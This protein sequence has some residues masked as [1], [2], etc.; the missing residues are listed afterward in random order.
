MVVVDHTVQY[1]KQQNMNVRFYFTGFQYAVDGTLINFTVATQ[2][3]YT[4]TDWSM[5]QTTRVRFKSY[6][7]ASYVG[8]LIKRGRIGIRGIALLLSRGT[9]GSISH[10]GGGRFESQHA[11]TVLA[12]HQ[13][14]ANGICRIPV[15][16]DSNGNSMCPHLVACY[17]GWLQP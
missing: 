3:L 9:C 7:P 13:N 15:C 11:C 4:S 5:H 1:L 8:P 2:P 17:S 6:S 16:H 14:G 10:G 12:T